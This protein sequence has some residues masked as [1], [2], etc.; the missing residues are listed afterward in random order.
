M[1]L[2]KILSLI[3]AIAMI[4]NVLPLSTIAEEV[5]ENTEA[6]ATAVSEGEESSLLVEVTTSDDDGEESAVTTV[7][8]DEPEPAEESGTE[9]VTASE[10]E[11]PAVTASS[12]GENSEQGV[13]VSS[14]ATEGEEGISTVAEEEQNESNSTGSEAVENVVIST[15][16]IGEASAYNAQVWVVHNGVTYYLN[17]VTDPVTVSDGDLLTV[18]FE[19]YIVNNVVDSL[20]DK[21]LIYAS[22]LNEIGLF[23]VDVAERTDLYSGDELIGTYTIIDGI[24]TIY[25]DE[26]ATANKSNIGGGAIINCTVDMDSDDTLVDGFE[27]TIGVVDKTFDVIYDSG[28]ADGYVT[29]E[30]STTGDLQYNDTDDYYYQDYAV[31]VEVSGIMSDISMTDV[32][33]S[34]LEYLD[35]T[36]AVVGD[37]AVASYDSG[38]I[39][40]T[41]PDSTTKSNSVSYTITYSAKLTADAIAAGDVVENTA[42][43]NY[44]DPT[45]GPQSEGSTAATVP[46][47]ETCVATIDKDTAGDVSYD[48][49]NEYFYQDYTMSVTVDG[50][51]SDI[52][53]VDALPGDETLVSGSV[54]VRTATGDTVSDATVDESTFT[55]TLPDHSG[56]DEAVEYVITYR[57]VISDEAVIYGTSLKNTVTLTYSD[58][59]GETHTDDD[60]VTVTTDPVTIE[61]TG[62]DLGLNTASW[63]TYQWNVTI[64]FGTYGA[65]LSESDINEILATMWD[66]AYYNNN[67]QL[68]LSTYKAPIDI[69]AATDNIAVILF[70]CDPNASNTHQYGY[71]T[72]D[73][74]TANSDGTYSM[75]Y[76]MSY[77]LSVINATI[78]TVSNEIGIDIGIIPITYTA[79][80]NVDDP[81]IGDIGIDKSSSLSY[82]P[83]SSSSS[84]TE[85]Y[86]TYS[87]SVVDWDTAAQFKQIT[88]TVTTPSDVPTSNIDVNITLD[89]GLTFAPSVGV[90][91]TSTSGSITVAG[92]LPLANR[93]SYFLLSFQDQ[94]CTFFYDTDYQSLAASFYGEPDTTYTITFYASIDGYEAGG[95]YS[96]LGE[97]IDVEY[98]LELP[99]TLTVD[100]TGIDT[101][102]ATNMILQQS[103]SSGDLELIIS[104]EIKSGTAYFIDWAGNQSVTITTNNLYYIVNGSTSVKDSSGVYYSDE[105][106][107]SVREFIRN[108]TITLTGSEY[109]LW[110]GYSSFLAS[111]FTS[112]CSLTVTRYS[113]TLD[114][115]YSSF[116]YGY[117][118]SNYFSNPSDSRYNQIIINYNAVQ[119]PDMLASSGS[120]SF[121]NSA[122]ATLT[123]KGGSTTDDDNQTLSTT[124]TN[125][126][127]VS[128]SYWDSLTLGSTTYE[129]TDDNHIGWYIRMDG[130]KYLNVG[131]TIVVTDTLPEHLTYTEGDYVAYLTGSLSSVVL[132]SSYL[133]LSDYATVTESYD[134]ST[135]TITYTITMTQK[136]AYNYMVIYLR[137]EIETDYYTTMC[138]LG[139]RYT[140]TNSVTAVKSGTPYTS[141]STKYITT[142]VD[143]PITKELVNVTKDDTKYDII[144]EYSI[145]VNPNEG[146]YDTTGDTLDIVDTLP[147]YFVLD[148]S[149]VTAVDGSGNAVSITTVYDTAEN[150]AT[151]TIPDN[152]YVT[153]T[154]KVTIGVNALSDPT[155]YTNSTNTVKISGGVYDNK[156]SSVSITSADYDV[157]VW[158]YQADGSV[159]IH[160]YWD[161]S[162]IDT[163]LAG[164]TFSIYTVYDNNGKWYQSGDSGYMAGTVKTDSDGSATFSGLS[165]DRIYKVAEI[166]APD[167]YL[168]V[169]EFYVVLQGYDGVTIPDDIKNSGLNIV[170]V[171]FSNSSD[172]IEIKDEECVDITV[173]KTWD[174]DS[175]RDDIRPDEVTVSLLADGTIIDTVT[176]TET[177]GW[178][179]T[180]DG[181]LPKY[182]SNGKEITYTVDET[183]A[184]GDDTVPSGYTKSVDEYE[185]TNTHPI[186]TT[187]VTVT[188]TWIDDSNN[189]DTRPAEVT[190]SLLADGVVYDTVTL[191]EAGG[192]SYAWDNLPKNDA[193]VE[194]TYTVDEVDANGDPTVPSNYTSDVSG[195]TITNTIKQVEISVSCTKTWIDPDGTT[196]P[197]IT[198]ELYQ[199][200]VKIDEA[201]LSDGTTT[202]EFSNL[203]KYDLTDGHVYDYTVKE[204]AVPGYT[205]AQTDN[206]FT[207][208]IEQE[209]ISVSGTKT[210]VDIEG[211]VHPDITI[212]LYQD[213]NKID[214]RTLS[215]GT[216]SYEFTDLDRYDLTDKC[217]GH[218]YVYTVGEITVDGYT[219]EQDGYNFTN[220]QITTEVTVNKVWKDN[221][222]QDGL[223]DDYTVTLYK[224]VNGVITEVDSQTLSAVTP[225]YTWTEL[226]TYEAVDGVSYEITYTVD[227]TVVPDE[228]TAGEPSGDAE[229]G[230]TIVNSHTTYVTEVSVTKVWNDAG[231]YDG[232][233]PDSVTIILLA[234]G[235]TVKTAELND[236]NDWTYTF[237]GLPVNSSGTKIVYTISEVHVSGYSC[238]ISGDAENGFTV[239]NLH[240]PSSEPNQ[241]RTD[242]TVRKVWEDDNNADGTRPSSVTVALYK[243][244]V[245]TGRT[246]T[247]SAANNWTASFTYLEVYASNGA[248]NVYTVEELNVPTGYTSTIS[249]A[250]GQYVIT[251]THEREIVEIEEPVESTDTGEESE[252]E[253]PEASE[254]EETETNPTTGMALSLLPMA[255]VAIAAVSVKRR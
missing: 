25:L 89:D 232:I 33:P 117:I 221:N 201:V 145:E 200:D 248:A 195:Y 103:I 189:D 161:N 11:A 244:G 253:E 150:I 192:W 199:D 75:E 172:P 77:Y 196:H 240:N 58:P 4:V 86:V 220:T 211:T 65:S 203:E 93:A 163:D 73:Q 134:D 171:S 188:K 78:T 88:I 69:N 104:D 236:E 202:Y 102:S 130:A 15:T 61:K 206:D 250:Y 12:E 125:Y 157:S 234:D 74:L 225:K 83:S 139:A 251:N 8:E 39:T 5:T 216:T 227:E 95:D 41:F 226:P 238:T 38:T 207:N 228:Y 131:D 182:D 94:Y 72:L 76:C 142:T 91:A 105:K 198:I 127:K 16:G 222:D 173:T 165:L 136:T 193:G 205:S 212:E 237:T 68:S 246:I 48:S 214:E 233:R 9:A 181:I 123:Y 37:G 10:E 170:E 243:N 185:I 55:I 183:D 148:E 132:A 184:N 224:T 45:D 2:R 21:V 178:T 49:T 129:Y 169:E 14:I 147:D 254:P 79:T 50:S 63:E 115:G 191:T 252:E 90:T 80:V 19:W 22:D 23:A 70:Y 106:Y 160:K 215:D 175:D 235:K 208:T 239:T 27:Q 71:I 32:L 17:D 113:W 180:W 31:T 168:E 213:G 35:G 110:Q 140:F 159:T 218:E 144:A 176:L 118:L 26:T 194:I 209:Y 51:V 122:E 46:P 186:E 154:Y 99:Y 231:D 42:T 121:Y 7:T 197:D 109:L 44:T 67:E 3:L 164:A 114:I 174:D 119:D 204:V 151:F 29:I 146:E 242:L 249:K 124:N 133:D 98:D 155:W 43:V 59:K 52:S 153:I 97:T 40:V 107:D 85:G 223:R 126:F 149:S 34:G 241:S 13:T 120:I 24:F 20:G 156:S 217:D 81:D 30:K 96:S 137:S 210:W 1:N 64:D 255:I 187:S 36:L 138:N 141:S 247:L 28:S 66:T 101:S 167:G 166:N 116:L 62:E 177:D 87:D 245:P 108:F 158:A 112:G 229:T 179:Y 57:A 56:T 53:I 219:T 92:P 82:N 6:V 135:R 128:K 60:D 190:V 230:F 143:D 47:S 84:F 162:G 111:I 18:S 100:L 152:T 54:E